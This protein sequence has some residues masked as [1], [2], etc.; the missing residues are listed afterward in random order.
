MILY[1]ERNDILKLKEYKKGFLNKPCLQTNISS[2]EN[3]L[4]KKNL[5]WL[6]HYNFYFIGNPNH[7]NTSLVN[8]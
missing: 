6:K 2:V 7:K 4:T 3:I 8:Y 5:N 1:I